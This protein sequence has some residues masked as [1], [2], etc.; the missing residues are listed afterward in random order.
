MNEEEKEAIKEVKEIIGGDYEYPSILN[1]ITKTNYGNK[2]LIELWY[3]TDDESSNYE[4]YTDLDIA[5]AI[6]YLVNLVEKQQK[7]IKARLKEIEELKDK[8][9]TLEMLLQ[10]NLFEMYKYYRELANSYQANCI[11]KDKIKEMIEELES[12]LDLA[13]NDKRFAKY[14]KEALKEEI[15]DLK[16][17]LG[18]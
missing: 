13:E 18:E 17:L 6:V 11:S 3:A 16:E 10:G 15:E 9:K 2:D 5:K 1:E 14:K 12:V 8:N 7:E 4:E